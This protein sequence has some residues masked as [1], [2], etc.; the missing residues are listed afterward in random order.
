MKPQDSPLLRAL[1]LLFALAAVPVAGANSGQPEPVT[2]ADL[3]RELGIAMDK[4]SF[5]FNEPVYCTVTLQ[6][7]QP[8]QEEVSVLKQSSLT[9]EKEHTVIFSRRDLGQIQARTGGTAVKAAKGLV[10]FNVS[11]GGLEMVYRDYDPMRNLKPGESWRRWT[12]PRVTEIPLGA[13]LSLVI[14]AGPWKDGKDAGEDL[15]HT[16]KQADGFIRLSVSFTREPVQPAPDGVAAPAPAE[17][18]AA[19]ETKEEKAAPA[20]SR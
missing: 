10:D 20:T 6:W 11:F 17:T 18:K 4:F 9:A 12:R 7:K 1:P 16:Y 5:N 15:K 2:A 19:K 8:G 14:L 13:E 3:A